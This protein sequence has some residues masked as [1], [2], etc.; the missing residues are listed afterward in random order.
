MTKG[1]NFHDALSLHEKGV[2]CV[3]IVYGE[4]MPPRDFPLSNYF[5]RRPTLGEIRRWFGIERAV[6]YNIAAVMGQISRMVA[7]DTDTREEAEHWYRTMPRTAAMVKSANGVH[8]WYR[9]KEGDVVR[10]RVRIAGLMRDIRAEL[11]CAMAPP[12]LHPSGTHYEWV[13]PDWELIDVPEFDLSWIEEES[14]GVRESAR[15]SFSTE[16]DM[17]HRA[18]GYL[19]RV[20]PAV[21]GAGGHNK[22]LYAAS[23]LIQKFGLSIDAAWPLLL[24]WNDRCDPPWDISIPSER[25][26][27]YRKLEEAQRLKGAS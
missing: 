2:S 20:E 24:E 21:Q 23:C 19:Q 10:S 25:R 14:N 17:V 8:F 22:A 1:P 27:L 15:S 6:Q 7:V 4:K 26:D 9:L 12:S 13:Y 11:S 16:G 3:P 18:R 5:H